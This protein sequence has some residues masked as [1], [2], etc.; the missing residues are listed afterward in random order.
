MFVNIQYIWLTKS[1][2]ISILSLQ[3]VIHHEVDNNSAS[4]IMFKIQTNKCVPN[5]VSQ[6]FKYDMRVCKVPEFKLGCRKFMK[7][8]YGSCL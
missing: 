6:H 3:A 7:I 5:V 2:V 4:K 1:G 8:M